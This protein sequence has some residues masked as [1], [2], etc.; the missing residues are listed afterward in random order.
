M[1][2]NGSTD[3]QPAAA[4]T[5]QM[6]KM[7]IMGQFVRDLSFENMM[8]QNQ[9]SGEVTPEVSE[10]SRV[11]PWAKVAPSASPPSTPR[12]RSSCCGSPARGTPSAP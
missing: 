6:P 1:A 3:T 5:P 4:A 9:I 7:Q 10:V 8:V 2:E 12:G 11:S